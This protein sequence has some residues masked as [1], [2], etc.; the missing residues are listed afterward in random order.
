MN[1]RTVI[2]GEVID[3]DRGL[4]AV[5]GCSSWPHQNGRFL[6]HGDLVSCVD[7]DGETWFFRLVGREWLEV[8]PA[9]DERMAA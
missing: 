9:E 6:R 5:A 8:M 7:D 1:P 3:T 2:P 4:M